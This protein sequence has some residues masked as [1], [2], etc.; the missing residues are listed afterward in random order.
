M[1]LLGL[2]LATPL[3][4]QGPEP[5][6]ATPTVDRGM[7]MGRNS[8]SELTDPIELYRLYC[9]TCHGDEGQGLTD[10]W[11]ESHFPEDKQNCWQ[12][13]CHTYNHDPGGFVLPKYVPP[14]VGAGT[15]N[16][17]QHADQLYLYVKAAMP[18]YAPGLLD[19]RQ[20]E[21]VVRHIAAMRYAQEGI[22]LEAGSTVGTPLPLSALP[23]HM[24]AN[25]V[26][27][28]VEQRKTQVPARLWG[29]IAVGLLMAGAV[30][31]RQ[32]R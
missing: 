17:F 27:L 19:D 6:P 24:G 10:E 12:S 32:R 23:L 31:R 22:N 13:K 9:S 1:F 18:Y 26:T 29:S 20:Y 16:N 15:L 4:A 21:G 8:N 25:G 28:V 30:R 5:A 7:G 14:L 2:L 11:R 3:G